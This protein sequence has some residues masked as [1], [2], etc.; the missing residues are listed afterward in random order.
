[1]HDGILCFAD[2]DQE[3]NYEEGKGRIVAFKHIP[4]TQ[5]IREQVGGW[6]E[7]DLLNGEANYYYDISKCGIGFHGDAET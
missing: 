3:P 6:M 7:E 4:L 2:E 5:R 1:M